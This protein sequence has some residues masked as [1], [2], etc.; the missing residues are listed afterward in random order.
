MEF[1][2]TLP[3]KCRKLSLGLLTSDVPIYRL[4]SRGWLPTKALSQ[5]IVSRKMGMNLGVFFGVFHCDW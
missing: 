4:T 3:F 5:K 2:R 1:N